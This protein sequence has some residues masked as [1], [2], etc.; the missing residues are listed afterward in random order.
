[1]QNKRRIEHVIEGEV[2]IES[3]YARSIAAAPYV[4]IDGN[5][6]TIV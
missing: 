1:M 2:C 4:K 6:R 5:I 3:T